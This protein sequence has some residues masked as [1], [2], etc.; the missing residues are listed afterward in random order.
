MH[1]FA[2]TI[3]AV[4]GHFLCIEFIREAYFFMHGAPQNVSTPV[5]L[6]VPSISFF[7]CWEKWHCNR[8]NSWDARTLL[9]VILWNQ[10]KQRL[11][12]RLCRLYFSIFLFDQ[13]GATFWIN[14]H[15]E[16]VSQGWS[17]KILQYVNSLLL[18]PLQ[19]WVDC[20]VASPMKSLALSCGP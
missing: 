13:T 3:V 19:L 18:H 7:F 9:P 17:V 16:T 5:I 8:W 20:S 10:T 14:S 11:H 15:H 12:L 4:E 2:A 6:I 1:R